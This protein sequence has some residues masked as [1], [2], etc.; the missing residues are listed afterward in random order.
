MNNEYKNKTYYDNFENI[1][2]KKIKTQI[3]QKILKLSKVR[4]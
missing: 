1:I 3:R 2:V 4:L